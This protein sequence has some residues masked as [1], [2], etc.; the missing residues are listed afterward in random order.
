MSVVRFAR[1]LEDEKAAWQAEYT[2]I[3]RDRLALARTCWI[4]CA[5]YLAQRGGSKHT[6]LLWLHDGEEPGGSAYSYLYAGY[7]QQQNLSEPH[8]GLTDH[9][10]VGRYLGQHGPVLTRELL[11]AG[12]PEAV[13][14]A[15]RTER[16][17]ATFSQRLPES[18]REEVERA[19][20]RAARVSETETPGAPERRATP[21]RLLNV[22]PDSIIETAA[23][24]LRT[25]AA[26]ED[27]AR[28][29]VAAMLDP[30][31]WL[32]RQP[33]AVP[34]CP[35]PTA[36]LHHLRLP[37]G[38]YRSQNILIG[39]CRAHHEA[40]PGHDSPAAHAARQ[41]AWIARHWPSEADFWRQV[42]ATY[43]E[44]LD[45]PLSKQEAP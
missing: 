7:A 2:R 23:E 15:L 13:R 14:R 32:S 16:D 39:L 41:S 28:T 44:Y 35:N 25:G 3:R 24:A 11:A 22:M 30:R 12:G 27:A 9:A 17:D 34:G 8:W 33:C 6:F 20:R 29:V 42:A 31:H 5:R 45:N 10:D 21:H 37:G 40:E 4:L 43:A 19:E 18:E 1:T 26:F 38:R 36:D